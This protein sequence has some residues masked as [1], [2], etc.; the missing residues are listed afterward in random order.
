MATG[1]PQLSVMVTESPPVTILPREPEADQC[2][3]ALANAPL[4]LLSA[5]TRVELCFVIEGRK[6]EAG[7][8]QGNRVKKSSTN[9]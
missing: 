7:R 6:G 9:H 8:A 1:S 2:N 4:R 3:Q 5:V